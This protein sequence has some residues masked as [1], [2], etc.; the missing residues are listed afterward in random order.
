MVATT[1]RIYLALLILAFAST[2]CHADCFDAAAK[3]H[4]V[5]P[6][7]LRAIAKVESGNDPRAVN[8]NRN[9]TVDLGMMQINSI[10]LRELKKYGVKRKDLMNEC[11]NI[12]TGAWLLRRK[13]D[14]H[15]NNW[16]AV[17]AYHSETPKFRRQYAKLVEKQVDRMEAV[18]IMASN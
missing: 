13:M 12:Y 17:G 3:V 11:K 6:T 1:L 7:V 4:H 18:R 8:R 14:A 15:G 2:T 16:K 5:S 10:H 9:G